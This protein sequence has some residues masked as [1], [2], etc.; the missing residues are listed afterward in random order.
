[1]VLLIGSVSYLHAAELPCDRTCPVFYDNDDRRDVYTDEY[2]LAL[3]HLGDI[4][5]KGMIT[6]QY[7]R[8]C[9]RY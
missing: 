9:R 6:S 1:M 5:L 8:L 3:A 7:L 2:L 4:E